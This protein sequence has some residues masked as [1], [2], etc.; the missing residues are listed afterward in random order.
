M[1]RVTAYWN[2]FR[3]E[4]RGEQP[5]NTTDGRIEDEKGRLRLYPD[6]TLTTTDLSIVRD[7]IVYG[8]QSGSLEE[9]G[10]GN[11]TENVTHHIELLE[12]TLAV[13]A[14]PTRNETKEGRVVST[15]EVTLDK[16]L[17]SFHRSDSFSDLA[18]SHLTM[19]ANFVSMC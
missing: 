17:V 14:I 15:T 19:H 3:A 9:I 13:P 1:G 11:E 10:D 4:I 18:I 12:V 5:N 16:Q 7:V 8:L 6:V 2:A